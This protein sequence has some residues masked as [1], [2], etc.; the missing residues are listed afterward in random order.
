MSYHCR[1]KLPILPTVGMI[2]NAICFTC[3][4]LLD[5]EPFKVSNN[6]FY[7]YIISVWYGC[8]PSG[9]SANVLLYERMNTSMT[10]R[11]TYFYFLMVANRISLY[12]QWSQI[13]SSSSF[14]IQ[15]VS[16][17]RVITMSLFFN[18]VFPVL[19]LVL[20]L[21][22]SVAK[23]D[24]WLRKESVYPKFVRLSSQFIQRNLYWRCTL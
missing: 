6:S 11:L 20:S 15:T 7:F 1:L 5:C 13:F 16:S 9:C 10:C 24:G 3:V 14:W 18:A 2:C 4:F 8:G 21:V 12:Y 23:A 17:T 22:L 19:S